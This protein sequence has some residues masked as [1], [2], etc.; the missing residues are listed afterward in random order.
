MNELDIDITIDDEWLEEDTLPTKYRASMPPKAIP[1]YR[2]AV[3]DGLDSKFVPSQADPDATGWDV[4]CAESGG[5]VLEAMQYAKIR[6]GVRMFAPKGW[7]LEL[8]P[9][10][11]SHFKKNLHCLY[12]VIDETYENELMFSC[13]Y[14]PMVAWT[15]KMKIEFG[16]RIGQVIPVRK[17]L[18][19]ASE[20]ANE[21][22]D[23]LC[24]K[25][26]GKRGT[27][28]FGST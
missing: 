25:R 24:E 10:S 21:E 19:V 22:F 12:G 9:R 15:N 26:G 5:V 27:G 14:V 11:S 4:R 28:G 1:I 18:M 13:Q 20:V 8:R 3:R 17:Q 23:R 6:L 7:W 2:F 16:E